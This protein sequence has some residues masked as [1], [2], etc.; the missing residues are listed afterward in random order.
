MILCVPTA[1]RFGNT[2]IPIF[3]RAGVHCIRIRAPGS[4]DTRKPQL[5]PENV[6][7]PE[8]DDGVD[9]GIARSVMR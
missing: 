2:Q 3:G 1:A 9:A 7:S 8:N 4:I 6:G 5:S